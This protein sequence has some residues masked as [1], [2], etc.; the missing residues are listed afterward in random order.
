[1]L[2]LSQY[3]LCN[4][5]DRVSLCSCQTDLSNVLIGDATCESIHAAYGPDGVACVELL[6]SKGSP[7]YNIPVTPHFLQFTFMVCNL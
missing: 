3:N 2:C 5:V 7:L 4:D 6:V 1:M